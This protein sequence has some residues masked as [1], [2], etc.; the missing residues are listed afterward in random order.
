MIQ[1]LLNDILVRKTQM[2]VVFY[3]FMK[4]IFRC[5]GDSEI[6][7]DYNT[8]RSKAY[9]GAYVDSLLPFIE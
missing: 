3:P 7:I 2:P 1:N 5:C 4:F 6:V 8:F 9:I